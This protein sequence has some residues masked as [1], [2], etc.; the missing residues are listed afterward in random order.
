MKK[1][2][3]KQK[4]N[5]ENFREVKIRKMGAVNSPPRDSAWLTYAV[6]QANYN[7]PV[8]GGQLLRASNI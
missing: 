2:T 6:A 8:N 7:Q 4:K 5:R 3:K 1:K